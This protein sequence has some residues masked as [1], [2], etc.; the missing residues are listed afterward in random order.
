VIKSIAMNKLRLQK[1]HPINYLIKEG[2]SNWVFRLEKE[3]GGNK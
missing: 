1:S 2:M 3:H